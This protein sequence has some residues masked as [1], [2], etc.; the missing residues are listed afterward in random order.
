LL[1]NENTLSRWHPAGKCFEEINKSISS[2]EKI[3]QKDLTLD[4]VC[5][6]LVGSAGGAS[7]LCLTSSGLL[8]KLRSSFR[9]SSGVWGVDNGVAYVAER[10]EKNE[11]F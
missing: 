8:F 4:F 9:E 7:A 1:T 5:S 11:Q 10:S 6:G 3:L 2:P